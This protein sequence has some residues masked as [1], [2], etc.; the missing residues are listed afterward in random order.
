MVS[1]FILLVFQSVCRG[2]H[3]AMIISVL[4]SSHGVPYI[5]L[6]AVPPST[7]SAL[8]L[9]LRSYSFMFP[10]RDYLITVLHWMSPPASAGGPIYTRTSLPSA[11][12]CTIVRGISTPHPHPNFRKRHPVLSSPETQ[13]ARPG[14]NRRVGLSRAAPMAPITCR[15]LQPDLPPATAGRLSAR[16]VRGGS[17]PS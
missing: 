6:V 8:P 1:D 15:A 12:C 13:A 9:T 2:S 10:Y 17:I 4:F 11:L 5:V 3:K 7:L 16:S 14:Y